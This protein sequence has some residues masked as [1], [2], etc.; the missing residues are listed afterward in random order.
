MIM[1]KVDLVPMATLS[2]QASLTGRRLKNYKVPIGIAN[3]T[4][5]QG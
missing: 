3:Y 5:R 2:F 4:T 1:L